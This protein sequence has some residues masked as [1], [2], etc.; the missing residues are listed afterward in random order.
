LALRAERAANVTGAEMLGF[1]KTDTPLASIGSGD[2]VVIVD[3]ALTDDDLAA[4]NRASATVVIGTTLP[5]GLT[6]VVAVLPITNFTEEEGT[7]TNLR[8]RVQRFLQAK[9]APGLARPSWYVLADLLNS[10]GEATEYF[11]PSDVFSA[12]AASHAEFA[13]LSYDTLGLRGLPVVNA[14]QA[15]GGAR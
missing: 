1:T 15:A 12:L 14:A 4:A 3:H 5:A 11:V 13:G 10:L 2:V 8:G 9:A 7:F 6:N